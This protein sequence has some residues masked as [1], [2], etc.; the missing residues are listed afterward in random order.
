MAIVARTRQKPEANRPK[1]YPVELA[2][3]LDH[4]PRAQEARREARSHAISRIAVALIA[5]ALAV[6]TSSDPVGAPQ[7]AGLL[8]PDS[9]T[10]MART[11]IA[12]EPNLGQTAPEVRYFSRIGPL[13]VYFLDDEVVFRT[14]M[15]PKR[16]AGDPEAS[17]LSRE[18]SVGNETEPVVSVLRMRFSDAKKATIK[19]R[20][21]LGGRSNYLKGQDPSK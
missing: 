16:D 14:L 1:R 17:R 6:P 20:D 3:K 10:P 13:S 12:F 5:F 11:G 19:A 4:Y 21:E 2:R 8:P 15:P 7:K 18:D 9:I